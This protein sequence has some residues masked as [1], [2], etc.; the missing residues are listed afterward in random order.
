MDELDQAPSAMMESCSNMMDNMKRSGPARAKTIRDD[1]RSPVH[2]MRTTLVL[3]YAI[4][5]ALNY[6]WELTQSR[7]Y[8]IESYVGTG[9]LS[10]FVASLGDGL[11][12]LLLFC[13]AW[14]MTGARDWPMP[15]RPRGYVTMMVGGAALAVVVEWIAVQVSHAWIYTEAM[16]RIP[17]TDIG[18]VPVLQM[19][20]LPPLIVRIAAVFDRRLAMRQQ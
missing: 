18:L 20:V 13:A 4:A 10:C 7:L 1:R 2:S 5:V 6:A 14:L 3:I 17:G 12:V 19:I 8:S 11:M 9:W 16:P 15:A